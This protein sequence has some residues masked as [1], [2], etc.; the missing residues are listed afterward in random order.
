MFGKMTL[1]MLAFVTAP[2]FATTFL[3]DG[4]QPP[5]GSYRASCRNCDYDGRYLTCACRT[6]GGA[7]IESTLDV[8]RCWD[9]SEGYVSNHESRLVCAYR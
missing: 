4:P 6:S 2:T 1:L 3:Q 7:W 9:I 5:K 8:S